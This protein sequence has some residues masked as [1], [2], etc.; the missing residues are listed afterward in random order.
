[1]LDS[2]LDSLIENRVLYTEALGE[3]AA[4]V[5]WSLL[6]STLI[7]LFLGICLVVLRPNHI[8]ASLTLYHLL[9]TVINILRS[10]PFIIILIAIIPITKWIVH[11]TIGVK[12]AIVP[13]VFYTAPYIARLIESALLEVNP[14]VIEAFQ[15]MGA[16]R[17]QIIWQ[18]ILKE[19]RPGIVLSLTIA[20]IGLIGATAMA[21]VMGAGGLGDVAIRYGYQRWEPEV[22]YVCVIILILL[23]QL[24][25]SI[26]N[27]VSKKLRKH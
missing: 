17:R 1:M 22:M 7:G 2:F 13:L 8:Y 20:T 18:V 24:M 5:G 15:A 23:V 12:G 6:F 10:V 3:T 11:T 25:Q 9:N 14:G 4:M 27:W 16:S 26:G 21:G 19:A